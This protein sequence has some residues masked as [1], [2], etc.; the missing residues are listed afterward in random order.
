[1]RLGAQLLLAFG[2]GEATNG[3]W[4]VGQKVASAP[5]PLE[6]MADRNCSMIGLESNGRS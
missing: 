5:F 3:V 2:W 4:V 1:M 6:T